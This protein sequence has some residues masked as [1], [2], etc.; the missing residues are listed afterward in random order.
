MKLDP[1]LQ[2]RLEKVVNSM[3][4][5]W[6]GYERTSQGNLSVLRFYIDSP[7]GVTIDACAEVSRQV[8]A[9]LDV[10]STFQGR[11]VLEVS[12]PG[13]ER[14]LFTLAQF[15]Q[16]VGHTVNVKLTVPIHQ[17]RRYKGT[18]TQVDEEKITVQVEGETE[19]AVLPFNA[20]EKAHLVT[21]FSI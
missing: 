21:T 19:A 2:A 18:L 6:W 17:R 1:Q 15:Q 8:S 4:Y 12:S 7:N 10:E 16:Y 5:T 20:I 11:Y 3:G 9:L 14:P 13:I